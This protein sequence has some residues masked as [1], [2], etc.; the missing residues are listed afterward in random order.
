MHKGVFGRAHSL[1]LGTP[2]VDP[3][4]K[5]EAARLAMRQIFSSCLKATILKSFDNSA[6]DFLD[7]VVF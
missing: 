4:N 3:Q 6:L 1:I 7:F 2:E 5:R